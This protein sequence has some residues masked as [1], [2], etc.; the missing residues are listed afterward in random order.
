MKTNIITATALVST[1]V[2][3]GCDDS[4]NGSDSQPINPQI[5]EVSINVLKKDLVDMGIATQEQIDY[6]RDAIMCGYNLTVSDERGEHTKENICLQENYTATV[7]VAG[8]GGVVIDYPESEFGPI[9]KEYHLDGSADI[10]KHDSSVTVTMSNTTFAYVTLDDSL[11]IYSATLDEKNLYE[12]NGYTYG[13]IKKNAQ[14]ALETRVGPV[15]DTVYFVVAQQ[16]KYS[17]HFDETGTVIIR[18]GF[19]VPVEMPIVDPVINSSDIVGAEVVSFGYDGITNLRINAVGAKATMPIKPNS[20]KTLADFSIKKEGLRGST[21]HAPIE[22][23]IGLGMYVNIYL[24]DS[25]SHTDP[26]TYTYMIDTGEVYKQ[27]TQTLAYS[28]W[29]AFVSENGGEIVKL[30]SELPMGNFYLRMNPANEEGNG[31]NT[32]LEFAITKWG[33]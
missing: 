24:G 26:K 8:A 29:N 32:D 20:T 23:E 12:G 9:Y 13:Y 17:V 25:C 18:D 15:T 14:L 5:R 31:P 21:F 22:M 30:C 33:L 27:S 28:D 2:I 19:G 11:D 10:G 1:I 4:S 3:T 6:D 16:T 7:D